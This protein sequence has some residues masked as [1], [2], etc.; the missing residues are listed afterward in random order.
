M[1]VNVVIWI[2]LVLLLI[3]IFI[4]WRAGAIDSS[5]ARAALAAAGA[6]VAATAKAAGAWIA[7][8]FRKGA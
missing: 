4:V 3:G 2:G 6:G 1:S 5:K 8:L 7:S